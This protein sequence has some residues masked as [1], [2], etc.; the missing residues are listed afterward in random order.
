M[1]KRIYTISLSVTSIFVYVI[2][3]LTSQIDVNFFNTLGQHIV[4]AFI[5]VIFAYGFFGAF[6][7]LLV[8]VGSNHSGLKRLILRSSYLEGVWVGYSYSSNS[9]GEKGLV[10]YIEQIR[11]TLDNVFIEGETYYENGKSKSTWNSDGLAKIDN[12]E[13]SLVYAFKTKRSDRSDQVDFR[14]GI[15]HFHFSQDKKFSW[16]H[17]KSP[18]RLRGYS[19]VLTSTEQE[20]IAKAC[21]VSEKNEFSRKELFEKAKEFYKVESIQLESNL[22][23]SND[24]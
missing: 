21:K 6:T 16:Y 10:F 9:R 18:Q 4:R 13:Y 5:N 23:T 8:T 17:P 12:T 7:K 20:V 15:A 22:E 11:Q 19:R 2:W 14:S 3:H 24:D 1:Y